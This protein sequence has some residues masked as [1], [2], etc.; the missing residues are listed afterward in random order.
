MP[1]AT[2]ED[3][4]AESTFDKVLLDNTDAEIVFDILNN[5]VN[6]HRAILASDRDVPALE[7]TAKVIEAYISLQLEHGTTTFPLNVEANRQAVGRMQQTILARFGYK[8]TGVQK[9]IDKSFNTEWFRNA[10]CYRK[11][12]ETEME[13]EEWKGKKWKSV[14]TMKIVVHIF[15]EERVEGERTIIHRAG[16]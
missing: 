16:L 1:K 11:L 13:N 4:I 8:S 10:S 3:F 9:P 14:A 15:S 2:F 12:T 5:D 6:I 7:H